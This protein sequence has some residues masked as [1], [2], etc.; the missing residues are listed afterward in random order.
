MKP[1]S[2]CCRGIDHLCVA[3]P[4]SRRHGRDPIVLDQDVAAVE[5]PICGIHAQ[6]MTASESTRLGI[7]LPSRIPLSSSAELAYSYQLG[8]R[9]A[10]VEQQSRGFSI[11][12]PELAAGCDV[13]S[14]CTWP[15]S[16]V[17]WKRVRVIIVGGTRASA[18]RLAE[19]YASSG[20]RVVIS[21]RDLDG[22]GSAVAA[23]NP[24]PRHG[25]CLRGRP[26]RRAIAAC[27]A[28][29]ARSAGSVI[30]AIDRDENS[31]KDTT[32]RARSGS[33]P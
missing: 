12:R 3:A 22:N 26:L 29:S 2:R 21:G 7:R 30:G 24:G 28:E 19:V 9:Q 5:S 20:R 16:C 33:S 25:G 6:D 10:T 27:L 1:G 4:R 23:S 13:D 11:G 17:R 31:V 32:S 14:Y 15:L 18:C 8:A